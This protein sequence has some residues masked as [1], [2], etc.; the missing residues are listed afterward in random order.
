M[1]KVNFLVV[2]CSIFDIIKLFRGILSQ[3]GTHDFSMP[4]YFKIIRRTDDC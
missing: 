2:F 4:Q 3:G 1:N